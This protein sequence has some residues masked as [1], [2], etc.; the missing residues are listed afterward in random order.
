MSS[1]YLHIPFCRQACRYCD[2]YF[3]VSLQYREELVNALILEMEQ[4]AESGIALTSLYLGGGTPSVLE[5]PMLERIIHT[6]GKRYHLHPDAEITLEAN[7]DDL[8]ENYLRGLRA[9]GFNRLSIGIQS[10]HDR[11]L[12]LMRRSHN[13]SQ[14][15]GSIERA[16]KAGFANLTLDLIY[17]IPGQEER[18]WK[19]NLETATSF[20]I[21]HLSAYHLTFEP[22]TV[23]HHWL[24][25]R[26]IREVDEAESQERYGLLRAHMEE[27]GFEH[28]EI[29]NFAR[30]GFRS[31]HNSSYWEGT[32]YM[33][34]GPAAHSYTGTH[35]R[36]NI[37]SVKKYI[38]AVSGGESYFEQEQLTRQM[39]F[40]ELLI[41]SLRRSGGLSLETLDQE[42][43]GDW[44]GDLLQKAESYLD[45]GIMEFKGKQLS[46]SPDHW[47]TSDAI[48]E[49]LIRV[50]D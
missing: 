42:F 29:S 14:A 49:R 6:I 10:F 22:G 4:R 37:A 36:W 15:R 44:S 20:P 26:R 28:Y 34:A 30:P 27:E 40:N 5:L 48:L 46:I 11:D 41:I 24:K 8:S 7:P 23:F 2:F 3:M 31:R 32:P 45:A 43:P 9:L 13:A 47:L 35:R 16:I 1:M 33:G 21:Q 39:R 12:E 17:G 25:K 50:D 18:S 38:K 19:M